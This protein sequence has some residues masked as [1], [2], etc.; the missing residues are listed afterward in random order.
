MIEPLKA[1]PFQYAGFWYWTDENGAEHGP[2][3]QQLYALWDLMRYIDP[4]WYVRLWRK[5]KEFFRDTRG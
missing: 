1:N 3:G 5:I 2:Y 4:P